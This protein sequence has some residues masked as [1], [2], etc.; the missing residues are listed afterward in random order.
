M[1]L[2]R[3]LLTHKFRQTDT[4]LM[5]TT[6]TMSEAIGTT[7]AP[8]PSTT[9]N[10]KEDDGPLPMFVPSAG[11]GVSLN[12]CTGTVTGDTRVCMPSIPL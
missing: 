4:Q 3:S 7:E 12:T 10:G 1:N 11:E 6:Y 5:P 9:A 8:A 2:P